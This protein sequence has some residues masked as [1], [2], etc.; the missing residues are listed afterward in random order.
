MNWSMIFGIGF[1]WVYDLSI[2]A[3]LVLWVRS[4]VWRPF[5]D[6]FDLNKESNRNP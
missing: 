6:Y 2:I 4:F 3:G 1:W 5:L